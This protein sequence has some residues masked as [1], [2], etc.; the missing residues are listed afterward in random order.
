MI[1]YVLA[2]ERSGST[3]VANQLASQLNRTHAYIE[4]NANEAVNQRRLEIIKANPAKYSD[5]RKVYHTH[6]FQALPILDK[7]PIQPFLIR[8]SR[9][10]ALD[11]LLSYFLLKKAMERTSPVDRALPTYNV[12]NVIGAGE[13]ELTQ[14]EIHAYLAKNQEREQLWHSCSAVKQTIYYEELFAG[15][16]IPKLGLTLKF[17]QVSPVEQTTYEKAKFFKNYRESEREVR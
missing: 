8:T 16:Q 2:E 10:N 7:F 3:W 13:I 15:V 9:R 11:Q 4:I 17:D 5:E 1:L 6:L 14:P 12:E